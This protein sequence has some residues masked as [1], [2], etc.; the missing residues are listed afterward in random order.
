[1]STVHWEEEEEEGGKV[2]VICYAKGKGEPWLREVLVRE[3]CLL[4]VGGA[5]IKP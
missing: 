3:V 2:Y 1:M 4:G 5:I